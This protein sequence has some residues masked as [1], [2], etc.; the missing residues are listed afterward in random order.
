M[1]QVKIDPLSQAPVLVKMTFGETELAVGTAFFYRRND[2]LYLVSNWH[3]LSGR[4]PE[5]K[6]P[7]ATHCGVP[8]RI[9]C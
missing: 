9:Y 2:K 3:N 7:L 6:E 8:D 1:A 4:H 5:T